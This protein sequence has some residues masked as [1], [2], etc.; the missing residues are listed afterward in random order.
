MTDGIHIPRDLA[1]A[2]GVPEDLDAGMVGPYRF[3]DPRRRRIAGWMYVFG[4][5]VLIWPGLSANSGYLVM[6]VLMALLAVWHLSASWRLEA[7]QDHALSESAKSLPFAVGH[8]S[9][10]ITFAGLRARPRWQVIAYS[11]ED[12]PRRRALVEVDAVDGAV[13]GPPYIEDVPEL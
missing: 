7:D 13:T 5:A 1:E 9:A 6:A 2:E 8:A 12:P 3:P 10:A 11:P 4:G